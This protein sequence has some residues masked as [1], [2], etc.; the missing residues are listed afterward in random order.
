VP[1]A[2]R[3]SH[4]APPCRSLPA[5]G[6]ARP[7]ILSCEDFRRPQ[8][9][10]TAMNHITRLENVACPLCLDEGSA[11]VSRKP[12]ANLLKSCDVQKTN[13]I[14]T[15]QCTL[16]GTPY[17]LHYKPRHHMDKY[18]TKCVQYNA[19][20]SKARGD[21]TV[22]AQLDVLAGHPEPHLPAVFSCGGCRVVDARSHTGVASLTTPLLSR[23]GH[24]TGKHWSVVT[25][26][27]VPCQRPAPQPHPVAISEGNTP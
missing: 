9:R 15:K 20:S 11:A 17:G 25:S 26:H 12:L 27:P 6:D 19:Y 1:A 22:T 16:Y 13:R 14:S 8:T 18:Y 4:Q 23:D 10:L 3:W 7:E 21:R 5:N 24:P 2:G